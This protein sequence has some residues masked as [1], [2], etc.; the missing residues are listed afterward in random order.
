MPLSAAADLPDPDSG[1]RLPGRLDVTVKVRAA[2]AQLPPRQR[3]AIALVHYEGLSNQEAATALSI[4]VDAVE[5]L[6]ARARRGLRA[7]L[8]TIADDLLVES[9]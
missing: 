4:S 7:Q 6:L 8:F 3:A 5:S 9:E 2:I 1:Q